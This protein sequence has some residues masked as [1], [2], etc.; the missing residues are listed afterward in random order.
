MAVAGI[1]PEG[2]P[3]T[4]VGGPDVQFHSQPYPLISDE[5]VG[6]TKK[7]Q[8]VTVF[9][10]E[11][12]LQNKKKLSICATLSFCFSFGL[13]RRALSGFTGRFSFCSVLYFYIYVY[14]VL[15]VLYTFFRL[16]LLLYLRTK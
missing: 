13:S 4:N 6:G 14:V 10:V 2:L 15:Y 16:L 1:S 9:W 5:G 11:K 7:K 8:S 3:K 12:F